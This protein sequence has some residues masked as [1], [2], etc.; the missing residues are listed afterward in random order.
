MH[1][2]G[3]LCVV[4]L[5]VGCSGSVEKPAKKSQAKADK[6]KEKKQASKPQSS[7]AKKKQSVKQKASDDKKGKKQTTKKSD[8]KSKQ[9][10]APQK[11]Q[12]TKPK[13]PKTFAARRM[14]ILAPGGPLVVELRMS[15][16]GKPFTEKMDKLVAQAIKNADTNKDGT[17]TWT[18]LTKNDA[19]KSGQYGNLPFSDETA[20]KQVVELYDANQ[21]DVVDR[22]ELPR[23]LTRNY[24]GAKPFSLRRWRVHFV[25]SR[26]ASAL[27][28]WLDRDE[29]GRLTQD[30]LATATQRL[31]SRDENDDEILTQAEFDD[32]MNNPAVAR[33]MTN[34]VGRRGGGNV[35][36]LLDETVVWSNVHYAMHKQYSEESEI[37]AKDWPNLPKLFAKLDANKDGKVTEAEL[38]GITKVKPHLTLDVKFTDDRKKKVIRLH[39]PEPSRFAKVPSVAGDEIISLQ[40]QSFNLVLFANDR[41]PGQLNQFQAVFNRL[42]ADKNK[43]LDEDEYPEA[44]GFLDAAFEALDRDKDDKVSYKEV[45]AYLQGR[46]A[47]VQSQ[48]RARLSDDD[49]PLFLYLDSNNDGRLGPREVS[50]AP[51]RLEALDT[52][53]N[54]YVSVREIPVSLSLALA[55]GDGQMGEAVFAMPARRQRGSESTAP[56]W[57]QKMDENSDGEIS[58]REFLGSAT[59]FKKMDK[60]GDQFISVGEVAKKGSQ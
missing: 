43:Y 54:G 24:G 52:N 59:M 39:P 44:N 56:A 4:A 8:K 6:L 10:K 2:I 13:T 47:A 12:P 3:A 16:D 37:T 38:K 28:K 41:A 57:F 27:L 11:K 29:N 53:R 14:L 31:K 5:L 9:Q 20:V 15:I 18:E 1:R 32:S 25:K 40:F 49:D 45:K 60:D 21:N 42:D 33:R 46:F 23:F 26:R 51:T 19:F 48:I 17:S 58:R 36:M 30:E 7:K 50:D 55:R 35:S 22:D 34:Q